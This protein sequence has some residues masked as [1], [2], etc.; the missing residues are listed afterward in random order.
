MRFK[1]RRPTIQGLR[2][3]TALSGDQPD[4]R[5]FLFSLRVCFLW[6]TV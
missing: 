4:G 3:K 6:P 2:Y 5:P 1:G